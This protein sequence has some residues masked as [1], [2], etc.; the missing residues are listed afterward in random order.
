MT[1]VATYEFTIVKNWWGINDMPLCSNMVGSHTIIF[2]SIFNLYQY[3][4]GL[5][6]YL[7]PFIDSNVAYSHILQTKHFCIIMSVHNKMS[8]VQFNLQKPSS[9]STLDIEGINIFLNLAK[10]GIQVMKRVVFWRGGREK[11]SLSMQVF[12]EE[13]LKL[14]GVVLDAY[15]CTS[16]TF[17]HS[18]I[19]P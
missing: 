18:R 10:T 7:C 11:D 3:W 14:G 1:H 8:S 15:A 2:R 4:V 6:C 13:L 9:T 17:S 16:A 19:N 5:C 12:I